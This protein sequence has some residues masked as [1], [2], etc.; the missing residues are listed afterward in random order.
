[1]GQVTIYL[2][3][4]IENKMVEAAQSAHLSK[5]KWISQIIQEKVDSQ[6]PL[7]VQEAA[8]TWGDFPS[9]EELRENIGKDV[10][11]ESF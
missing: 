9:V 8:G 5:S 6:W 10:K 11:R 7:L 3:D 4:E 1:M 2:E